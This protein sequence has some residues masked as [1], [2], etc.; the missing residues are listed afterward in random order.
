MRTFY[1]VGSWQN[2]IEGNGFEFKHGGFSWEKSDL[3]KEDFCCPV[4]VGSYFVVLIVSD[5]SKFLE[6]TFYS[7]LLT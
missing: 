3:S 5:R 6:D 4:V 1:S 7:I 2:P